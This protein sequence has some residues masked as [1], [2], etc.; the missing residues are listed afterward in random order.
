MRYI[1]SPKRRN[2]DCFCKMAYRICFPM[3]SA[4]SIKEY[5]MPDWKTANPGYDFNKRAKEGTLPIPD[6]MTYWLDGTVIK[7]Y[8]TDRLP[9]S[10]AKKEWH[11]ERIKK[12][13][14]TVVREQVKIDWPYL[15]RVVFTNTMDNILKPIFHKEILK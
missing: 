13:E 9:P 5:K 1:L 15:T 4:V 8:N 7:A 6:G 10:L 14:G 2:L 11:T 12:G 3:D